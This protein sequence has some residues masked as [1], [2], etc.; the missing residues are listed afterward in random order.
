M[1]S[2]EEEIINNALIKTTED[3]VGLSQLHESTTF[4]SGLEKEFSLTEEQ[5]MIIDGEI[6]LSIIGQK[7]QEG[8]IENIKQHLSFNTEKDIE[9]KIILRI[10]DFFKKN[11]AQP[12]AVSANNLSELTNRLTQASIIT[13]LK[14]DSDFNKKSINPIIT[15]NPIKPT[16]DPYHEQ[17]EG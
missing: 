4:V 10:R 15:E 8:V 11:L 9:E 17:I 7:S 16:I 5:S 6:T 12:L 1:N 13:S 14:H 3:E 2:I